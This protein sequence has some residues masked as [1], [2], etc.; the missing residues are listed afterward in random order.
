MFA[1]ATQLGSHASAPV[2]PAGPRPAQGLSSDP[3]RGPTEALLR[4]CEIP[5]PWY[6]FG[7]IFGPK[8]YHGLK[9]YEFGRITGQ[10]PLLPA[11]GQ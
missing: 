9:L 7:T 6:D 5:L 3:G 8:S 4:G 11:L 10:V 2:D 1:I